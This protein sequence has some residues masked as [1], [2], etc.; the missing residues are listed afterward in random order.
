MRLFLILLLLSPMS[1]AYS[2]T[3]VK[4]K[5]NK[6]PQATEKTITLKDIT[7]AYQVAKASTYNVPSKKVFL[8]EYIRFRI[9]AEVA[10]H[11][12][13]LVSSPKIEDMITHSVFKETFRDQI[14]RAFADMSLE[15]QLRNLDKEAASISDEKLKSIYNKEPEF[16]FFYILTSHPI[17]PKKSQIKEAEERAKKIYPQV[18][19]SSKPFLELVALYSDDK[20]G[21]TLNLNRSRGQIAPRIY[22]ALKTMKQGQISQPIKM[23]AGYAIIKLNKKIPF[24]EADEAAIKVN[25]FNKKRT[26][27]FNQFMDNFKKDFTISQPGASLFLKSKI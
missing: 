21:G 11:N 8:D 2:R 25:Y 1:L 17:N 20:V 18:K 16:N 9:G 7:H 6:S 3:I 10:L 22:Q 26:R 14:Y 27:I 15:K 5:Y 24:H 13:K 4:Y 23:V 19:T 12:K